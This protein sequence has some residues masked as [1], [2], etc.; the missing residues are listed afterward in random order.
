[1]RKKFW[2]GR[3]VVMRKDADTIMDRTCDHGWG[4]RKKWIQ[5]EIYTFRKG[6][7]KY[8]RHIWKESLEKLTLKNDRENLPN[9]PV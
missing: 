5:K 2:G 8:P 9:D 7:L 1:M 4:F 3:N 6:K